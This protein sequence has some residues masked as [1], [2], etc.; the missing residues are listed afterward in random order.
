MH[1]SITIYKFFHSLKYYNAK[2]IG[3]IQKGI[4]RVKIEVIS[5]KGKNSSK[6]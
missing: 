2:N 4:G 5:S 1:K 6:I 3:M